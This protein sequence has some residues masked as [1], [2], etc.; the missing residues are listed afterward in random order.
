M[1]SIFNTNAISKVSLRGVKR[2]SN[3]IATSEIATLPLVA[4]ND[5]V[6]G[7]IAFLLV[8]KLFTSLFFFSFK[9]CLEHIVHCICEDKLHILL[10]ILGNI[11]EVF[12]FLFGT[13][14]TLM[15]ILF[16][17][18]A[19]S[20]SPPIGRTLPLK[21]TSPVIAT[22]FFTGFP[23]SADAMDVAIVIPAEGPILGCCACRDMYVNIYF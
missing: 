2:R 1:D 17:A 9:R 8:K 20:L 13:I 19:F 12:L 6:K 4:R 5:N 3:L 22:S 15:P 21:V 11:F 10:N 7:F 16:A 18:S 14:T 23:V